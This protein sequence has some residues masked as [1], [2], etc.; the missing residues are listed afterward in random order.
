[1]RRIT[2]LLICFVLFL[3]IVPAAFA[4]TEDISQIIREAQAQAI[5]NLGG[6]TAC[7]GDA[8][9]EETKRILREEY[10]VDTEVDS[11]SDFEH[12]ENA[13]SL[14]DLGYDDGYEAGY[15][16]GVREAE[17]RADAEKEEMRNNRVG[18]YCSIL[19]VVAISVIVAALDKRKYRKR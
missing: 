11:L 2:V 15:E 8:V 12:T 3:S 10:G 4:S 1:M 19:F 6:I 16:A 5:R 17:R 9:M 13:D 7:D 14:Y 18:A